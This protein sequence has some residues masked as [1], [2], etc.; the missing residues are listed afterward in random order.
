MKQKL[1]YF[2]ITIIINLFTFIIFTLLFSLLY[3]LKVIP[4]SAYQIIKNIIIYVS[5]FLYG[6][7]YSYQERKKG[8]F[9]GLLTSFIFLCLYFSFCEVCK[10]IIFSFYLVIRYSIIITIGS[11]LGAIVGDKI[12]P[13]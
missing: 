5:F 10:E 13:S 3:N 6:F 7:L 8:L 2:S 11:M 4:S 12:N 9:N 1:V